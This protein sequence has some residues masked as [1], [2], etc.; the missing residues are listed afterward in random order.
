LVSSLIE[1][2][3]ATPPVSGECSECGTP[4]RGSRPDLAAIRLRVQE[5]VRL[6]AQLAATREELTA[7]HVTVDNE[8]RAAE[9]AEA[10]ADS[11][12]NALE[13]SQRAL[14]HNQ[15]VEHTLGRTP[16]IENQ[17]AYLRG[18]LTGDSIAL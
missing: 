1:P 6:R 17:I 18:E 15:R 8:R 14:A 13:E 3:V 9:E 10:R 7:A 2:V 5:R 4:F 16:E 12:R 11:G